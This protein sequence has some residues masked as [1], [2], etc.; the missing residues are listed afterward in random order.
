MV[1]INKGKICTINHIKLNR[2]RFIY[3][4]LN[5]SLIKGDSDH[6]YLVIARVKDCSHLMSLYPITS[7]LWNEYLL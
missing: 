5:R 4:L 7:C 2:Q 3:E 6:F 1:N